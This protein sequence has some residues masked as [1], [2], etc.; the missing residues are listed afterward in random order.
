[1]STKFLCQQTVASKR[2]KY[3]KIIYNLF[4]ADGCLK[5]LS[6]AIFEWFILDDLF[7]YRI[8][9]FVFVLVSYEI[10]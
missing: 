4:V 8:Y 10:M 2:L 3:T 6:G 1:M 5:K 9:I 7:C